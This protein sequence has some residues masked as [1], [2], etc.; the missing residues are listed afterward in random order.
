MGRHGRREAGH[1]LSLRMLEMSERFFPCAGL[2]QLRSGGQMTARQNQCRY[3]SGFVR[4]KSGERGPFPLAIRRGGDRFDSGSFALALALG[5]G[6][7]QINSGKLAG[8]ELTLEITMDFGGRSVPGKLTGKID[9]NTLTGAMNI[10]GR[11]SQVTG[12]KEPKE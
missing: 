3:I 2:V 7:A 11:D 8:N 10:M 5:M 1:D 6:S 9:G 4:A 12:T